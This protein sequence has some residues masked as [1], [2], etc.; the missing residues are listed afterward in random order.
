[1]P[2]KCNELTKSTQQLSTQ[3]PQ[4]PWGFYFLDTEKRAHRFRLNSGFY[5]ISKSTST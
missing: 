2:A 5:P 3:K 1:V 4:A